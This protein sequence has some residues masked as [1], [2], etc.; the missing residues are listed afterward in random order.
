M[1]AA[2]SE[3]SD[4]MKVLGRSSEPVLGVASED[5]LKRGCAF[6]ESLQ[7][8][9]PA[10]RVGYIPKG[11]YRFKT[12]ADANAH[13]DDC[14]AIHMAQLSLKRSARSHEPMDVPSSR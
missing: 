1:I 11:V 14:L 13:Q 4:L 2:I 6:N 8:F 3:W 9:F 10:G 12:H 7:S 5:R